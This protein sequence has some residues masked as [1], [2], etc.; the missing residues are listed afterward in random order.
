MSN[1]VYIRPGAQLDIKDLMR[2]HGTV[3]PTTNTTAANTTQA[4]TTTTTTTCSCASPTGIKN[5]A[6]YEAV[7]TGLIVPG[8]IISTISI[9]FPNLPPHKSRDSL[10]RLK[11]PT[12]D[13]RITTT[14]TLAKLCKKQDNFPNTWTVTRCN[15]TM[16]KMMDGLRKIVDWGV[17]NRVFI[18][19][20]IILGGTEDTA[21]LLD[22]S[23]KVKGRNRRGGRGEGGGV[24]Y[25]G[26]QDD[27]DG[28]GGIA[29]SKKRKQ[30]GVEP[31]VIEMLDDSEDEHLNNIIT[32]ATIAAAPAVKCAA[33]STNFDPST[34]PHPDPDHLSLTTTMVALPLLLNMDPENKQLPVIYGQVSPHM[35]CEFALRDRRELSERVS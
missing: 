33:L 18:E 17:A 34:L 13:K 8:D 21:L 26:M 9:P 5:T 4:A 16:R 35:C 7:T 19:E 12:Y 30:K 23:T 3:I 11:Y 28:G 31:E 29:G 6:I 25:Q 32:T 27:D 2:N 22:T 15:V 10:H 1:V 24:D 20:G 14:E